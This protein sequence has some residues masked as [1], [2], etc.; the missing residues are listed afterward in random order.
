[1]KKIL[2]IILAVI[3]VLSFTSCKKDETEDVSNTPVKNEQTVTEQEESSPEEDV[4]EET[5]GEGN[6]EADVKPE[7]KPD[8]KPETKPESNPESKPEVKPGPEKPADTAPKTVGATLLADF[9]G[10]ASSGNAL[11]IAEGI[12]T[13]SIIP[14]P[15]ATMPVEP[16]FLNGFDNE[17]TGFD[18]GVMFGP[19]IGTIPFIGYV[20]T[21][22]DTQNISSFIA[23]LKENANLRWNIC[24]EADEMVTGSVGNKVFFVMCPKVFEEE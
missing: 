7:T 17:I 22:N 6:D 13:N 20:F 14:F 15:G 24:T 18:E 16:G 23:T 8:T 21:V 2:A 4:L 3:C 19:M 1:M 12:L 11:S 10:K 5:E 9:K